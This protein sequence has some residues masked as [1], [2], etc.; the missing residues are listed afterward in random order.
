MS[1]EYWNNIALIDDDAYFTKWVKQTGRLDHHTGFIDFLRPYLGGVMVDI[2]AN[3]GTHTIAYLQYGTVYAFEPNRIAFEC[4]KHNC[5]QAKLFNMALGSYT[6][7]ID[8]VPEGDNYG[9]AHTTPGK[10]IPCRMLDSFELLFCNYI[11]IDV[12]G[13]EIA[14]LEG[15]KRTIARCRPV[16]CIESN[17]HTLE[18]K[19]LTVKD[20]ENKILSLNYTITERVPQDISADLLCLPTEYEKPH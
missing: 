17:P 19:G 5:P 13:D 6:G 7:W 1:I 4:L 10:S 12:E 2:G 20:L 16:M 9:A 3:I 14:V 15:A 8:M 18:R 11:K